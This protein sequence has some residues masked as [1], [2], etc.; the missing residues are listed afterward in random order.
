[1]SAETQLTEDCQQ[2][3]FTGNVLCNSLGAVLGA[4][5]EVDSQMLVMRSAL[6]RLSSCMGKCISGA[7]ITTL[8]SQIHILLVAA[9]W[10]RS[11]LI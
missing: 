1:M 9:P 4:Q 2:M 8:P 3:K 6:S 11:T 10:V 5:R 7:H